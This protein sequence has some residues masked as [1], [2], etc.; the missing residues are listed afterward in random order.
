M[1][2][3]CRSLNCISTM[4]AMSRILEYLYVLCFPMLVY[5]SVRKLLRAPGKRVTWSL[6][7]TPFRLS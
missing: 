1:F 2:V 4:D 5:P 6:V 7:S 3:L